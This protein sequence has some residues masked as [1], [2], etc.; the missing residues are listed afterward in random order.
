MI[1]FANLHSGSFWTS[2]VTV[3]SLAID[4]NQQHRLP[5]S[6]AAEGV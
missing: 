2:T 5:C 6:L 1:P 4:C 3:A